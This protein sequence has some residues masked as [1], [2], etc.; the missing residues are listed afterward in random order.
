MSTL[1]KSKVRAKNRQKRRVRVDLA[2]I[3]SVDHDCGGCATTEKSCCARYEVCVTAAELNRIILLLPEVVKL[4]PHLGTDE[5]YDNVFEEVGQGLF[6]LD[7]TEDGLC[8]F[9]FVLDHKIRCS[10]HTVGTALGLPLNKVKPKACLL[11]PLS[12]S[13]GDEVLSVVDD[14]L[15]FPCNSRRRNQPRQLCSAFLASMELVY[16]EGFG[17]AL[18]RKAGKGSLRTTLIRCR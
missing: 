14:A 5:G 11:W 3:R 4:C 12:F 2:S 13:E 16:G 17:T 8:T 6:A 18:D 1:M 7:T 15:S 9:T 10:L